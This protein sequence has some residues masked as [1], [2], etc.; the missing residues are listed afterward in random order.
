MDAGRMRHRVSVIAPPSG[1]S[2]DSRGQLS[3]SN[4]T[5]ASSV[6][7]LVEQVGG[8][9]GN[10]ARQMFASA[11]HSVTMYVDSQVEITERCWL[12]WGSRRLNIRARTT[13]ERDMT[14][15]LACEEDK[16]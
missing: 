5:L 6:P 3:G 16:A 9:E 10:M 13:D 12:A 15:V 2:L 11:T 14:T 8:S 7:C 1:A 4:T